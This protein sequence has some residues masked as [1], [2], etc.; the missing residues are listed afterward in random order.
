MSINQKNATKS[1]IDYNRRAYYINICAIICSILFFYLGK[2]SNWD[3]NRQAGLFRKPQVII[4]I[5]GYP[6][7]PFEESEILFGASKLNN[8]K[9]TVITQ[10]PFLICNTGDATLENATITFRYNKIL[11]RDVLENLKF[12]TTGGFDASQI[13]HSFTNDDNLQYS[14]YNVPALNPKQALETSE[15]FFLQKTNL[16]DTFNAVTSD[17]KTISAKIKVDFGFSFLVSMYAKD[18]SVT[19]YPILLKTTQADSFVSLYDYAITTHINNNINS[20]RK[21]ATFGQYLKALL[22]GIPNKTLF[23]IY[24]ELDELENK[25]LYFANHHPKVGKLSYSP[26]SWYLLFY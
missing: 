23:I 10:I 21:Q 25:S 5:G 14:S 7:R 19:D 12:K 2:Q 3:I 4:G 6:I 8:Y 24:A 1:Q 17:K 13:K 22:F 9:E 18:T 11:Q 15:P 20:Y 16:I 26:V